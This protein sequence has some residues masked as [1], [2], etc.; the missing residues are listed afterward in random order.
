M[1][2]KL[3]FL[4]LV[5]LQLGCT[6][7]NSK[8]NIS[9]KN[10]DTTISFSGYWLSSNYITS[11]KTHKSPSLAQKGSKFITIPNRTL[12]TTMLLEDFH[13]NGVP[14]TLLLNNDTLEI[15]NK[16]NGYITD[17]ICP[18]IRCPDKKIQINNTTFEQIKPMHTE[19]NILILEEIL[20]KGLYKTEQNKD[21]QFI[22]TGELKG[23]EKYQYYFPVIDYENIELPIDKI[24]LG[25]N[26]KYFD[27]Y[28]FKFIKNRLELYNIN[29]IEYDSINNICNKETF[30]KKVYTLVKQSN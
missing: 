1:Q 22:N 19:N 18:I 4:L 30:G 6:N 29:C 14:I 2:F 24:G 3:I 10:I 27:Y 13:E 17:F 26:N 15:W 12:K 11:L 20:F 9:Y 8:R 23:L 25:V 21:V 16:I 28:G 7:G 5:T